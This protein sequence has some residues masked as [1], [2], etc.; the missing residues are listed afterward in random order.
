MAVA[1]YLGPA[2]SWI[3]SNYIGY[4]LITDS[5][6]KLDDR[7]INTANIDIKASTVYLQTLC[8]HIHDY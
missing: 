5:Y 4:C 1:E 6:Y 2:I 7:I 3:S 8:L